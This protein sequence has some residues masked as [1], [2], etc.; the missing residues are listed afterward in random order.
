[1][2]Q[3]PAP[4]RRG[5]QEVGGSISGTKQ[6]GGARGR[7]FNFRDLVG[8]R[9]K[10]LLLQFRG[11]SGKEERELPGSIQG[12]RPI[13]SVLKNTEGEG[14][15]FALLTARPSHDHKDNAVP[16]QGKGINCSLLLLLVIKIRLRVMESPNARDQS[17]FCVFHTLLLATYN[18][19]M[20]A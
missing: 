6:E 10:S 14:T 17:A 13:L 16:F 4:S 2:V 19:A 18:H 11:L 7:W 3:F 5:E 20:H 9:S 15:Y 12:T 8:E 1:M